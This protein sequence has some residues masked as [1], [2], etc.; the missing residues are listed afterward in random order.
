MRRLVVTAGFTLALLSGATAASAAEVGA[1][2]DTAKFAADGGAAI[3]ADMTAVGLRR[4]VISVRFKPSEALLIQDKQ[5]LDRAIPNAVRA[6]LDVVLAV[7]PYPP[8]EIEAGIGSPA[9]FGAY[10][11]TVARA[12]PQVRQFV[13]GNEPNQPAF[14]RPQ[15]RKNGTNASAPAFGRYLAAGYD[16]LKALDPE[17]KVVG[18]GLSPRGNDKP[19]AKSNVSTS[20]IRFLRALG[21]WYRASG[22]TRP[23]MDAFSFHPY[24][25]RATDPLDR[26]YGWPNAGFVNLD[27][28]KQALW[29]AFQGTAQPTTLNGLKLHLDEVGWQVDTRRRAGYS[30]AENVPVTDELTQARIYAELIRRAACDP[31]VETVS[32]FGFRDD[33][34]RTGFQAAL[35]RVD[36]TARP[37]AAAVQAAIE[38]TAEGCP[39][40]PVVWAPMTEVAGAEVVVGS[41]TWSEVR[42]RVRAR[43]DIRVQVCVRALESEAGDWTS[44]VAGVAGRLAAARCVTSAVPGQHPVDVVVAT[45]GM[46]ARSVE[47]AVELQAEA[48]KGRRTLILREVTLAS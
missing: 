6:G 31:D 38:E 11:S 9:A 19:R 14:W 2:D 36:G 33:G 44:R 43:E 39:S 17:L 35:H 48:N 23:L 5:L 41:A 13:I 45:D 25:N 1:N 7:Y 28:V 8:R 26:G 22:R 16:A 34:S 4:T 12:Y 32:F 3:Y 40:A 27:R 29:D 47:V 24:P 46:G 18:I 15:F 10:V 30:G 42:A 21:N 20:P 37:A